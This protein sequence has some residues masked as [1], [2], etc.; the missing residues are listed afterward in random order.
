MSMNAYPPRDTTPEI[1]CHHVRLLG[2]GAADPTKQIGR[3][4]SVTRTSAGLY[5]LTWS[6]N[7]GTFVGLSATFGAATPA[8]LAG[9]TIVRDTFDTS[10]FTLEVLMSGATE[11]AHDLAANEYIDLQV[12]FTRTSA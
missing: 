11:V 4:I 1:E 12:Y 7:P 9:H 6:E 3:G 2:T 5:K 8:D 10:A